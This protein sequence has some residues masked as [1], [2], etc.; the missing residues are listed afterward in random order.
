MERGSTYMVKSFPNYA[1]LEHIKTK[2]SAKVYKS[3][4]WARGV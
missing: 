1:V 2:R 4:E 3:L